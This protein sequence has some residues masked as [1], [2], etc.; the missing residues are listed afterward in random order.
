MI[1][2]LFGDFGFGSFG[3]TTQLKY[4]NEV[5]LIYVIRT[6]RQHYEECIYSLMCLQEIQNIQVTL[7]TL[8]VASCSRTCKENLQ[9]YLERDLNNNRNSNSGGGLEINTNQQEEE[10][11]EIERLQIRNMIQELEL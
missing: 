7:R 11:E 4:F 1:L 8:K 3:L 6:P 10:E 9:L 5:N 2:K